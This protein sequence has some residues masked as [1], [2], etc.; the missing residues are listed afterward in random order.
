MKSDDEKSAESTHQNWHAAFHLSF[1]RGFTKL[2]FPEKVENTRHFST[3]FSFRLSAA[4]YCYFSDDRRKSVKNTYF[5]FCRKWNG[6]EK[7]SFPRM[8]WDTTAS[9]FEE[10]SKKKPRHLMVFKVPTESNRELTTSCLSGMGQGMWDFFERL[11]SCWKK[12][13]FRTNF[14]FLIQISGSSAKRKASYWRGMTLIEFNSRD[15]CVVCK[16]QQMKVVGLWTF[17]ASLPV[18]VLANDDISIGRRPP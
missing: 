2:G 14:F 16:N 1:P 9:K 12:R 6:W 18:F 8:I 4:T 7:K 17:K 10:L 13:T 11:E 15:H 3:T 5:D